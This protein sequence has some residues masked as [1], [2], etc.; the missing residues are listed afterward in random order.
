[1][2]KWLLVPLLV[3]GGFI[4][5]RYCPKLKQD[6]PI[7]EFVEDEIE[8]LGLFKIDLSPETPEGK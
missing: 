2:I 4:F 7:E 8:Q 3:A 5:Y 1:M 6:N